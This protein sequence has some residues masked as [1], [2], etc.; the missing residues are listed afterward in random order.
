MFLSSTVYSFFSIQYI[1]FLKAILDFLTQISIRDFL[2][3]DNYSIEEVKEKLFH[4][5]SV[6]GDYVKDG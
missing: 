4:S 1:V 2:N 5:L 3:I 6:T